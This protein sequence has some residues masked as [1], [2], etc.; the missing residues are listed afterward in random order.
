[1][2]LAESHADR[3]H[4]STPMDSLVHVMRGVSEDPDA[5][6]TMDKAETRYINAELD[7]LPQGASGYSESNPLAKSGAALGAFDA[8]SPRPRSSL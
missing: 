2:H 6:A 1:M 8:I 5:Y 7:K 3:S 4:L